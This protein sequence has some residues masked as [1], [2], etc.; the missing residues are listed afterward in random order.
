MPEKQRVFVVVAHPDDWQIFAG[1]SIY[2]HLRTPETHVTFVNVTAGDAGDE[3]YHWRSRHS[4]AVFSILR[5]L[6][7][8]NPYGIDEFLEAPLPSGFSLSHDRVLANGK[9][10]LATTIASDET[11]AV[12]YS[13]NL[14]DGGLLGEGFAPRFES[15]LKFRAGNSPLHALWPN[16][17][18]ST[19]AS[20]NE[21]VDVLHSLVLIEAGDHHDAM[22]IYTP[23][24]DPHANPG[25]HSDHVVVGQAVADVVGRMATLHP[26]WI[27][28]YP[29]Q[30]RPENLEGTRAH[31]QR[32]A[33]YA[34]GGGYMASAALARLS[35]RH[36]W[37]SEYRHFGNREY[38]REK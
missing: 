3:P 21:L 20:W 32:A 28:M 13:L 14:P 35:W 31:L 27:S 25:D 30:H 10:V 8:W 1:A 34:Y 33:V 22:L 36:G 12:L 19:Y 16:E 38:L 9:H 7:C 18:S 6:S 5:G 24:P 15:L 11:T 4:G 37:E 26:R 29:N 17:A 2:E 23:D